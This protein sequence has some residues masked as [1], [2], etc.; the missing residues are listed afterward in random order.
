MIYPLVTVYDV[1]GITKKDL[2]KQFANMYKFCYT[3]VSRFFLIWWENVYSCEYMND[4]LELVWSNITVK[5][6]FLQCPEHGRYS[7]SRLEAYGKSFGR[8]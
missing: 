3:N 1:A 5:H 2:N 6:W 4:W 8:M 7:W